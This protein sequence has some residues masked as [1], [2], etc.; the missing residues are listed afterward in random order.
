MADSFNNNNDAALQDQS[1]QKL[2]Y[3]ISHDMS[4]PLRAVVQFSELLKNRLGDRLDEKESYWLQLIEESG[5]HAQK[6]IEALLRY[7][8][9]STHRQP[10]TN[11]F[12]QSVLQTAIAEFNDD[13]QKKSAHIE[14]KGDWP[15]L[16]ACKERWQLLFS[17]LIENALLYQSKNEKHRPHIIISYKQMAG[18]HRVSIEDNGIG[19]AQNMWPVL[20]TPFKR[21][22]SEKD[23]PGMGMG[24]TYCERIAQLHGGTLEFAQSSLNGLAVIYTEPG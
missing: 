7:S 24:L 12:L 23:Y 11:F 17:C 18:Q 10:D 13:I 2:V 1:I 3:G 6:M 14:I 4:A 20:T 16:T 5:C 22:Q 15:E 19:V 8:R 21:M 9:L